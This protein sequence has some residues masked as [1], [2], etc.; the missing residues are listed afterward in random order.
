MFYWK[1]L[2]VLFETEVLEQVWEKG[3]EVFADIQWISQMG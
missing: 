1:S 2:K 3:N